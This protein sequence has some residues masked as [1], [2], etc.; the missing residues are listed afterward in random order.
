MAWTDSLVIVHPSES[1]TAGRRLSASPSA[2]FFLSLLRDRFYWPGM[3]KD[4]ESW[5]EQC[6]RCLRRKTPTNQRAPLVPIVT[7]SPLELVCM[8]F[9]TLDKSKGGYQHILVITDHYT[10]YAQAIPTKNQLAKTTAEAFFNHFIVHLNF[11]SSGSFGRYRWL[12]KQFS[13]SRCWYIP[14]VSYW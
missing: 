9:L 11:L 7:S 8:D 2:L 10:R 3:Y 12:F 4:T 1:C 6:V 14:D 5:I 13:R